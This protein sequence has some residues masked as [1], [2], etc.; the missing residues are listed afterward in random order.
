MKKPLEQKIS[1]A[2]PAGKLE[3]R[4]S[5]SSDDGDRIAVICH[6]HPVYGGTMDNKVVHTLSRALVQMGIP[7]LRFNFRGVGES[8][9]D[10]DH[11]QGE[12]QDLLAA[13]AWLQRFRP[14]RKLVLAGF[15]FGSYIAAKV[16]GQVDIGALI[17]VAPPVNLYNFD[18]LQPS[19]PW[20]VVMGEEDEVVPVAEVRQ[21]VEKT[22]FANR[23]LVWMPE[24][25]H[26]FHG[27]L[28]DLSESVSSWMADNTD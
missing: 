23:Q 13:I 3:A 1:I 10:F 2:G 8:E 26:F 11:A 9:G 7:V 21:W 14:G 6:P 28:P 16:A 20:L 25:S 4:Y 24:T 18:E 12:Q 17:S 27:R 22:S 15:S 19:V 5:S